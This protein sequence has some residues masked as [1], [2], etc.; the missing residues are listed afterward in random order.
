MMMNMFCFVDRVTCREPRLQLVARRTLECEAGSHEGAGH[1]EPWV[2][3]NITSGMDAS[4]TQNRTS[5]SPLSPSDESGVRSNFQRT[6][7][8][9]A[10]SLFLEIP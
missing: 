7:Q 5:S 10:C 4:R 8:W 6:R 3:V 2:S 9:D 1:L